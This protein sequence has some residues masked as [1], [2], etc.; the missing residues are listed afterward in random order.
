MRVAR[1]MLFAEL[2]WNGL[3]VCDWWGNR[4][5]WGTS[6]VVGPVLVC[7]SSCHSAR[8][9]RTQRLS[10]SHPDM[11]PDGWI[12]DFKTMGHIQTWVKI[13]NPVGSH[14]DTFDKLSLKYRTK[15]QLSM[16]KLISTYQYTTILTLCKDR[17]NV[18]VNIWNW[19]YS[20]KKQIAT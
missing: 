17:G 10:F 19:S 11:K 18:T 7:W 16:Y 5:L 6:A 13:V 9:F 2:G 20:V 1:G 4:G 14:Q 12:T 15:P 3:L 8:L